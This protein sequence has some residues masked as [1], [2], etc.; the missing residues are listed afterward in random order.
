MATRKNA[1]RAQ[2]DGVLVIDKPAGPTSHDIV[3]QVKRITGARKVGHLGTLDPA[4]TGVLPLVI[5]GATKRAQQLSGTEKIY[6]FTLKLGA[7]TDTDDDAGQVVARGLLPPDALERLNELLPRFIGRILQRPPDYSAIK[8]GG[9]RA[10]DAARKGNA[11]SLEP[12]FVEINSLSIISSDGA[13]V[14]MRLECRTGT[15]VRSLARDIGEALGSLGH[16]SRIR[17]LRSGPYIIDEAVTMAELIDCPETWRRK[18][19]KA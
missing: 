13:D 4:A 16:A 19:L 5:N 15:Y 14:R 18:L 10:Y 1:G 8:V 11:L 7:R 17:R 9:L 3:Q 6:E 12:R 2:P